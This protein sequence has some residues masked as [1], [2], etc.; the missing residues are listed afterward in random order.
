MSANLD[1]LKMIK[2]SE[3]EINE[4]RHYLS[5]KESEIINLPVIFRRNVLSPKNSPTVLDAP[6]TS[7]RII[8]K[9]LNDVS[10]DQFVPLKQPK[11]MNLFEEDFTTND[12]SYARFTFK[13]SDIDKN[14]DYQLITQGLEFLELLNKK[15]HKSKNKKGETVKSHFGVITAP[16]ITKG[17][18]TFL[19]ASY[20]MKQILAM[21]S[22]NQAFYKLAW[23]FKESK[24]FLFYSWLLELT[25]KGTTV[26]FSSFQE[27]LGYNY[28]SLKEF[29]R[30]VLK[31][32]K[33]KLDKE[34]NIS[35][36]YNTKGDKISIIPY[37]VVKTV[38]EKKRETITNQ[39]ITQ[40][41][42]YWRIRHSLTKE[43]IGTLKEVMKKDKSLFNI[44][45][46]AYKLFVSD[47]QS[48]NIK[49][50]SVKGIQ[51]LEQFQERIIEE[52]RDSAW[53]KGKLKEAYPRIV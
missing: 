5:K 37:T 41:A 13:V 27:S 36:N 28:K 34:G 31:K 1:N 8:F 15:W 45:L 9:I 46:S 12:N 50:D 3:E 49:T 26:N 6:I 24:H 16:S 20:W 33:N 10:N 35:F 51:F 47:A 17:K 2:E 42:N 21:E 14:K 43:E 53:G 4:K 22:Y 44:F 30:N 29:N 11:Q 52:Y 40:K 39:H 25:H 7:F 48:K 38:S 32:I 18:I 19:M 23:E